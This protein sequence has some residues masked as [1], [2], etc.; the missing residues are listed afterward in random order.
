[1]TLEEPSGNPTIQ[2]WTQQLSSMGIQ[3]ASS[4]KEKNVISSGIS[5]LDDFLEG[6]LPVGCVSEWGM[7][8][9]RGGRDVL[10]NWLNFHHTNTG[11]G[12]RGSEAPA[13]TPWC[14]WVYS[15]A[16][17]AVNPPAWS[18]RGVVLPRIRFSCSSRPLTDLK[19]VFLDSF[20]R[21]VILDSPSSFTEEDC[22]FM[23]RRARIN[24][25]AILLLRDFFLS[26]KR[27]NVWAKM[28]LNCW[29]D[30]SSDAYHLKVIRGSSPR[31]VTVPASLV[32]QRRR[33]VAD[34]QDQQVL[35]KALG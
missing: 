5:A 25:Q 30:H 11:E 12:P 24:G 35:Y 15:K 3:R 13:K 1:M 27:G 19:P 17:L 2:S 18:S 20:F 22:A 10:L 21:L 23:A 16:H 9:G 31:E 33:P 28:R 26:P 8:L 14:L 29:H 6:G 32:Q 7:P 4:Q 34:S